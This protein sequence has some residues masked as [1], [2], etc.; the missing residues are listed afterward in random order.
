MS[1]RRW[2][3]RRVDAGANF[4]RRIGRDPILKPLFEVMFNQENRLRALE[5]KPALTRTQAR[6]ALRD[7]YTGGGP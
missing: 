4:D 6:Q 2:P 7:R 1:A 5:G 3:G